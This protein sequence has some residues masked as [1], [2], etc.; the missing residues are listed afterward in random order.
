[1]PRR[2][3]WSGEEGLD[4]ANP[5]DE[6]HDMLVRSRPRAWEERMNGS[7]PSSSARVM[8]V[9]ESLVW[10]VARTRWPVSAACVAICAVS[11]VADLADHDHVGS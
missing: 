11:S 8:A 7:T 10:S 4:A 3:I 1:M 6:T 2:L 9:G 5:A